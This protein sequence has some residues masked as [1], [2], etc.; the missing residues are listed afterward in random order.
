MEVSFS[1]VRHPPLSSDKLLFSRIVITGK[2][3]VG[4]VLCWCRALVICSL[5][6]LIFFNRG[7]EMGALVEL[8]I[9]SSNV[10]LITGL[11]TTCL[12]DN[13]QGHGCVVICQPASSPPPPPAASRPLSLSVVSVQSSAP[14]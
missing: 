3:C 5:I 10:R 7:C 1:Y 11:P 13:E 12:S 2:R 4:K 8:K 6:M 14:H 9:P